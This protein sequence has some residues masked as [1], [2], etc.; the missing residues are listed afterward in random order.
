MHGKRWLTS[1]AAIPVLA[2]LLIK[3]PPGPFAL[4]IALLALICLWEYYRI[5]LSGLK[6]GAGMMIPLL[7]F[8]AGFALLYAVYASGWR[9]V[10]DII[11]ANGLAAA[12]LSLR[13]FKISS[14]VVEVV[15]RQMQGLIYIPLALSTLILL[16]MDPNGLRWIFFL[17]FIIFAGDAGAFYAGR[18]FGR[19]K[20]SPA[21]SPGKTVEGAIGGLL[22]NIGV[23]FGFMLLFLPALPPAGCLV[24]CV[25][26]GAAGQAGDLFE[27]EFKRVKQIKD[28]GSLL[29]GHGGLLDRLDALLF[30]APTAY[31]VKKYILVLFV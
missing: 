16:R 23:G 30:A 9:Y 28:S 19:H 5:V 6:D 7:G 14:S 26:V 17:L 24:F 15:S 1:I 10:P 12:I 21:I 25:A 11:L 2:A 3:A 29:P 8:A 18:F 27:S 13:R 20:L 22:V 31:L 4:F